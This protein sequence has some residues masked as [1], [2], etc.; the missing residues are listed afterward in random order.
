LEERLDLSSFLPLP[1]YVAGLLLGEI[2]KGGNVIGDPDGNADI[3][4]KH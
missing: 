1:F 3:I 4:A 2:Q